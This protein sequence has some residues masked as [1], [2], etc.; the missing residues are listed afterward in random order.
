MKKQT[1][2]QTNM[3]SGP[4]SYISPLPFYYFNLQFSKGIYLAACDLPIFNKYVREKLLT[5]EKDFMKKNLQPNDKFLFRYR[6][7]TR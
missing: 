7:M 5:A 6:K 2:K 4:A 3:G 1:N